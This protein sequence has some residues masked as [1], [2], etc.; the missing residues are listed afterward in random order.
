MRF[1]HFLPKDAAQRVLV[2]AVKAGKKNSTCRP[3]LYLYHPDG[4]PTD[5]HLALLQW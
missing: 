5:A 1:V 4:T 2:C 3:P